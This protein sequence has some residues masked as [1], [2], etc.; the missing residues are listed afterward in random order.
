MEMF[1]ICAN[2]AATCYMWLL[3]RYNVATAAKELIFQFY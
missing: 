2:K 3:N 1:C